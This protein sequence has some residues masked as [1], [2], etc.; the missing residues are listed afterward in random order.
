LERY[1][2]IFT[3]QA[4]YWTQWAKSVPRHFLAKAAQLRAERPMEVLCSLTR[5][6]ESEPAFCSGIASGFE[7][8]PSHP[9]GAH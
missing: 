5:I 7:R 3:G 1:A 6:R 2:E 4:W 9:M 8:L